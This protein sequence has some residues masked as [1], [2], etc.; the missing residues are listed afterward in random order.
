MDQ[1]L[2]VLGGVGHGGLHSS[3][4]DAVFHVL[5]GWFTRPSLL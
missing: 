2:T 5:L 1:Q 4:S 3:R